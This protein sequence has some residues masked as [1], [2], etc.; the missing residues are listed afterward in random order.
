MRTLI[1]IRGLP[2]SGKTTLAKSLADKWIEADQFFMDGYG[3]YNF[4]SEK[5]SE[6]HRDCQ[7]RTRAFMEPSGV[8]VSS[9]QPFKGMY[10]YKTIAVSNTFAQRWHMEPYIRMAEELGYR[11]TVISLFDNGLT[12]EE[13]V[14]RTIHAVPI[15]AIAD[16]RKR[17]EHDWKKKDSFTQVEY[18]KKAYGEEMVAKDAL[19]WKYD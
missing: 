8:V 1:L 11:L 18:L 13:L 19:P 6:A 14:E 12:D 17:F 4:D 10:E 9:P 15:E 2:G 7:E 16:M 3:N 5:L